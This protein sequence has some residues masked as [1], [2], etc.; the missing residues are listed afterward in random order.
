[1]IKKEK[2]EQISQNLTK[3]KDDFSL[4]FRKNLNLYISDNEITLSDISN[5]SDI[6]W[7]T[8]NSFLYGKSNNLRIDNVVRLARAL[9]VSIDE[10][11]GAE[12]IPELSIES[13]RLCRELS[14]NDLC[15]VRWFIRYL[16]SLEQKTPKKNR[17]ISVMIPSIDNDGNISVSSNYEKIDIGDLDKSIR[18][19]VFFGI[20]LGCDNYMPNYFPNDTI[21][22]ANDRPPKFTEHVVLRSGKFLYLAKQDLKSGQGKFFSIRDGKYRLELSDID[23]LVGYIAYCVRSE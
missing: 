12:T 11:V 22:I 23:E 1:M 17:C 14:E 4:A 21:L 6:P 18:T 2:L 8:L 20:Q 16:H 3:N 13:L 5:D 19:K 15:L 7:N 9:N 10:L